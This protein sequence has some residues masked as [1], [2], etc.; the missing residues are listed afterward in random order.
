MKNSKNN[1]IW[2]RVREVAG[3]LGY[4]EKTV[5]KWKSRGYVPPRHHF[6]LVHQAQELDV[7]LTY[8]ELSHQLPY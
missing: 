7:P 4:R 3:T 8:T 5:M 2:V 6:M 1:D